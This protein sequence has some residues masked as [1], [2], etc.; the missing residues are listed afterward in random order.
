MI[1]SAIVDASPFI[2]RFSFNVHLY[3]RMIVVRPEAATSRR[4][5]NKA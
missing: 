4:A 3:I 1:A 5:V 2:T